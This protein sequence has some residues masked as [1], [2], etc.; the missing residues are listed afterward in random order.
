[1]FLPRKRGKL[2][3]PQVSSHTSIQPCFQGGFPPAPRVDLLLR[4]LPVSQPP[5]HCVQIGTA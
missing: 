4:C 1:M 3:I 2:S 5:V